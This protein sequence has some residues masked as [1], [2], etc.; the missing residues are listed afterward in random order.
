MIQSHVSVV[1]PTELMGGLSYN[2]RLTKQRGRF[3]FAS[4]ALYSMRELKNDL[5]DEVQLAA[6]G[7]TIPPPWP[8]VSA[9]KDKNKRTFEHGFYSMKI[10]G[11]FYEPWKWLLERHGGHAPTVLYRALLH[12]YRCVRRYY[13]ENEPDHLDHFPVM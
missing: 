13:A 9:P 5:E 6:D 11:S 8:A 1:L 2:H 7:I 3:S 4:E 10:P 12:Q